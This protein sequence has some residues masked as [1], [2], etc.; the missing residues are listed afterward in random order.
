M[1]LEDKVALITGAG[2]GIGRECAL[3]IARSGDTIENV[4]RSLGRQINTASLLTACTLTAGG[5]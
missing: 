1:K 2:S 3:G 4:P 5:S